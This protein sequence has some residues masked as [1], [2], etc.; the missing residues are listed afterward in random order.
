MSCVFVWK[1][2]EY[3]LLYCKQGNYRC[4][5]CLSVSAGKNKTKG[6]QLILIS[7]IDQNDS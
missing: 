5:Y 4:V 1:Y 7:L 6:Q 3:T 2:Q